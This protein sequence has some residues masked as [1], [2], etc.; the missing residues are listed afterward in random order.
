MYF[1]PTLSSANDNGPANSDYWYDKIGTIAYLTSSMSYNFE[2]DFI[3][4]WGIVSFTEAI[5]AAREFMYWAPQI[6]LVTY[7]T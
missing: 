5:Y 2:V 4:G 1:G 7:F 6:S 3:N